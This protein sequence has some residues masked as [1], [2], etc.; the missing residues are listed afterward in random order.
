M[1]ELPPLHHDMEKGHTVIGPM[2]SGIDEETSTP[3]SAPTERRTAIEKIGIY[4]RKFE[5]QLVAYNLEARGIQRVEEHERHAV[6]WRDYLQ[7]F[8]FWLSVNLVGNNI[9]LGM[10]APT[11]FT[12]SF[13]DASLCAVFGSIL[14]SLPVSWIAT[15][16]PISG[17]RT[18]VSYTPSYSTSTLIS[19]LLGCRYLPATPWAGGQAN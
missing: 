15:R 17:N 18:M 11:V 6:G 10:L 9:T 5:Q 4:V 8:T 2:A 7:T 13:L 1:S 12:L 14:G 19:F 3:L 16:G